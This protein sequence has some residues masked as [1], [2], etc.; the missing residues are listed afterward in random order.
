MKDVYVCDLCKESINP[1]KDEVLHIIGSIGSKDELYLCKGCYQKERKST[2][3]LARWVAENPR[4]YLRLSSKKLTG[5]GLVYLKA[6]MDFLNGPPIRV[7][8]LFSYDEWRLC[9]EVILD[10]MK[11]A[12]D[13]LEK[14]VSTCDARYR[15]ETL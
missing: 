1:G 14:E 7:A 12:L 5:D 10:G 3:I 2:D 11:S 15:K 6:E 13:H 9:P 4:Y 8:R